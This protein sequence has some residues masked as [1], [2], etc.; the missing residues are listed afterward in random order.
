MPEQGSTVSQD[1]SAYLRINSLRNCGT[2]KTML[3]SHVRVLYVN[4]IALLTG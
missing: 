2:C 3:V 1:K 4:A